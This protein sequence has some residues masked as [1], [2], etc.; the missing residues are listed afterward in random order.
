VTDPRS[1]I[2]SRLEAHRATAARLDR[3][4]AHVASARL[5][6]FLAAAAI[7]VASFALGRISAAWL[8]APAGAYAALAVH[9]DRTLR[10]R[11][12]AR[13]A[14]AFHEAA[15]ARMDDEWA[16]RGMRGDRFVAEDHPYAAD[17]DLFGEASLFELLCTARTRPGE[18]TLA[19]WLLAPATVDEVRVRQRA[20]EE[21]AGRLDLREEMAIRGED[22]RAEVDPASIA[23]WAEAPPRLAAPGLRPAAAT[24]ALVATGT[25]VGWFA[26]VLHPVAFV[27]G[28]FG[29]WGL[30]RTV[31]SGVEHALA[32]VERPGRELAVL[33]QLLALVEGERF[34]DARLVALQRALLA[35]SSPGSRALASLARRIAFA[36]WAR[37][38]LFAP[39]A[40]LLG[41]RIQWALAV[42]RWRAAHGV[43]L[44][45]WIAAIGELEALSALGTYRFEHPGDPF[46]ELADGGPLL[47]AEGLGHPLIAAARC[48]RNDLRLG[49]GRRLLVVSGSN[50][51]GK[52]TFL[53]S[54]G[55]N[56][57]LALAG[58]PV[59]ARRMRLSRLQ[60]GGTLR[61]QDS[62]QG[63]RS[64]F[65]AE[66]ERLKQLSDLAVGA[67]PLLF[68]VDEVLHGT[69]SHDRRIGAEAVLRGLLARGAIGLATT[70]DLALT[71]S[72][73]AIPEADNAHF[74][75]QVVDGRITFDYTL[76]PG[77]VA[78]SN[79]LAL[80][81]AVGLEV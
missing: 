56:V 8:L 74:E 29:M 75:D 66:I 10:R 16:G 25:L 51:S 34:A 45:R 42:E 43:D 53:R 37:N 12:L 60:T 1:A 15:L 79:A 48:V 24:A 81:R 17:L 14:I 73:G 27:L 65:Y 50:M 55:A 67:T 52:S 70:H 7:A 61:I 11:E 49:P 28:A 35:G 3:R 63:G 72:A 22:V 57:V 77:V 76:R 68:L 59:R 6:L 41:W 80:M 62:L 47:E 13:R 31:K 78:R 4:D 20:V 30:S 9:H 38:Q 54:A 36:E 19:S 33:A 44:R 5:V 40:F 18:E 71:E 32:G 64:R 46:P 2:T 39:I 21:L 58:A 26:G 69:N 23:A